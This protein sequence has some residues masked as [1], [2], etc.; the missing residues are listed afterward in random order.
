MIEFQNVWLSFDG[1]TIL[2]NISLKVQPGEV[3]VIVGGSGS[4]KTTIL[5]LIVGL[6]HPDSG[7]ILIEGRDIVGLSEEQLMDIRKTMALVFQD[8]ALFDSL[9]VRENVGYRLWEQNALDEDTINRKV[10]ESLRFVGLDDIADVMPAE[11]S[12]GM[13]KRVAIARALAS[14][15]R[16][17]LYDEPT[18]GLDPINTHI[19]KE[20]ICRL[21]QMEHVTQVVVTHDIETAYRVAN[22]LIMILHGEK[23]FDGTIAELKASTDER[24]QSFLH[25]DQVLSTPA[26]F[27]HKDESFGVPPE[28]I[29][30]LPT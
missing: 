7:R 23:I 28:V 13:R 20:L 12:G 21:Q 19:V 17:I 29:K 14:S 5:R 6:I 22:R 27:A 4:G 9:T 2:K 11:L 1:S 16:V 26:C 15:P 18:A 24:V 3:L 25:P 8:G 10:M 30:E